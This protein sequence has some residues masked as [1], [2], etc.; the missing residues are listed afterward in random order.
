MCLWWRDVPWA[1][2]R[3]GG[4]HVCSIVTLSK[5]SQAA[6]SR[7]SSSSRLGITVT[8]LHRNKTLNKASCPVEGFCVSGVE[9]GDCATDSCRLLPSRI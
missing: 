8:V 1:G 9:R 7:H 3:E 5:W 2:S 6:D 4:L